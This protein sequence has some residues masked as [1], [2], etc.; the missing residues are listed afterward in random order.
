M[1]YRVVRDGHGPR[2]L[3]DNE[4]ITLEQAAAELNGLQ[5]E[6]DAARAALEAL[7][8]GL[9][10]FDARWKAAMKGGEARP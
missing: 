9:D 6:R 10:A 2:I 4:P 8:R 5:R 3:R 1:T 7:H